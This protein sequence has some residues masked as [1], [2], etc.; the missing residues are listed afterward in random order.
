M[1]ATVK[2]TALAAATLAFAPP[3]DAVD[4]MPVPGSAGTGYTGYAT[5]AFPG[6]DA[7]SWKVERKE[8]SWWFSTAAETPEGQWAEI[9]SLLD[10]GEWKAARRACEALVREWP[11]TA[12]AALAQEMIGNLYVSRL[13]D[14]WEAFDEYDYLLRFYPGLCKYSEVVSMQYKIAEM[15][16]EEQKAKG[17]FSFSW[18]SPDTIRRKFEKVVRYAP[19]ADHV[20]DAMMRIAEL[21]VEADELSEAVIV[22]EELR[23]KFPGTPQASRALSLEAET[24]MKLVESKRNNR[25]RRRDVSNFMRMAIEKYPDHPD[26]PKMKEWRESLEARLEEEAWEETWFYDSRQRSRNAAISAYQRFVEQYPSSPR[27]ARAK[28]RI[29]EIKGGAEPLRK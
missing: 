21:R 15:M 26:V 27:A 8:Q 29:E 24:L 13:D 4:N 2:W 20:P 7:D 22:F 9:G 3:A 10:K 14:I 11:S 6:F 16:F 28:A 18:T 1:R 5:D 19:G 17:T 23:S 12:E 25:K